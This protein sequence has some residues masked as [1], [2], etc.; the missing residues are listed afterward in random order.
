VIL[1]AL[2]RSA[3]HGGGDGHDLSFAACTLR[4]RKQ[5][6]GPMK[7]WTCALILVRTCPS[8]LHGVLE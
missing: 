8:E 2:A 7:T 6:V 4:R 1:G 5:G 3:C